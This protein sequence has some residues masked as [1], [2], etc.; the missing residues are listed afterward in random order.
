MSALLEVEGLHAGYG[1]VVVLRDISLTVEHGQ[2]AV[3]L[4]A[5][6]AGKTTLLRAL[7]GI[8][9]GRGRVSLDGKQLLGLPSE[10]I[11]SLGVSHVPQGRGT[12]A[13]MTV[14]ENLRIGAHLLQ[15][16][17]ERAEIDKWYAIF[18]RLGDRSSQQAGSL[19]GG[20]QQMLAVAR[21]LMPGPRLLLLDEPSLGLAPNTTR[22]L[23]DSLG[24]INVETGTA[25]LIVEQNA[26][27]ALEIGSRAMLL[28]AGRLVSS[29]TA[30][31]LRDND[32]IRRAY[33]GY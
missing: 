32:D 10:K 4:G 12:F 19:S 9:K 8:I 6:G 23:F 11:A 18:P 24:R 25:M 2:V 3:V 13:N 1:P 27:L 5:N 14:E 33:L 7:S 21:A 29:G 30:Q 17:D 20:E 26:H 15:G 22:D 28:E 31:E 16:G